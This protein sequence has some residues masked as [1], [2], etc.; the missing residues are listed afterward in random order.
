MQAEPLNDNYALPTLLR[1]P[2]LQVE[3]VLALA[4]L[5]WIASL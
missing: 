4:A 5:L 3:A 2:W 1:H